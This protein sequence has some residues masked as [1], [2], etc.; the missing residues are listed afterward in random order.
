MFHTV[1]GAPRVQRFRWHLVTRCIQ[2]LQGEIFNGHGRL[3][4]RDTAAFEHNTQSKW[5]NKMLYTIHSAQ[6]LQ[7]FSR[8]RVTQCIQ[9]LRAKLFNRQGTVTFRGH[10]GDSTQ[11]ARTKDNNISYTSHSAHQVQRLN[12]HRVT[13]YTQQSQTKLFNEHEMVTIK[14]HGADLTEAPSIKTNNKSYTIHSASQVQ[15]L[16]RH[17]FTRCIQELRRRS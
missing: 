11:A 1:H 15:R 2:Q 10:G 17:F 13:R 5:D 12:R 3:P 8:H 9:Q 6:A 16:S 7:R 4:S 14:R